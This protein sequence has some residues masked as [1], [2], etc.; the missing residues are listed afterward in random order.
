MIMN[1]SLRIVILL[2]IWNLIVKSL[3]F[4][5][6]SSNSHNLYGS[7]LKTNFED[8]VEDW[9]MESHN[10]GI[11]IYQVRILFFLYDRFLMEV[12]VFLKNKKKQFNP[13][14]FKDCVAQPPS[15]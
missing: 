14:Y 13:F 1:N 3:I 10:R 6:I 5:I 9:I 15:C 4:F 8:M 7:I 2:I 11:A 12:I